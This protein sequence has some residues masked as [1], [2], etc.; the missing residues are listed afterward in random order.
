MFLFGKRHPLKKGEFLIFEEME[1]TA[2]AP[3]QVKHRE[4]GCEAGVFENLRLTQP[5]GPFGNG[6]GAE[7]FN[8]GLFFCAV[9]KG[10]GQG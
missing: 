3:A 4:G 6:G 7:S 5:D 8:D 10:N 2:N 9:K 1:K